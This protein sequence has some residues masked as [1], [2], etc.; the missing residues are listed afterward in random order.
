MLRAFTVTLI[1]S[2]R[3]FVRRSVID[4]RRDLVGFSHD[5]RSGGPPTPAL[6]A[7]HLGW[8]VAVR[9]HDIVEKGIPA[10]IPFIAVE[11][12]GHAPPFAGAAVALDE[13]LT[14]PAASGFLPIYRES[15]QTFLVN[16]NPG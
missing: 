4:S 16:T 15:G 13:F 14:R 5:G 8:H 9:R 11:D 2:S 12:P 7:T 1:S 6:H 3:V 10:A